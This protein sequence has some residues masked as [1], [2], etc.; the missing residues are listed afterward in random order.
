MDKMKKQKLQ[1][2]LYTV[3]TSTKSSFYRDHYN[4]QFTL[5]D[6]ENFLEKGDIKKIPMLTWKEIQSCHFKERSYIDGQILVKI[7]HRYST[8]FLFARSLGD[9][10]AEDYG[11]IGERPLMLF[12]Y[13]HEGIEKGLWIYE[14][15]ILPLVR[16]E[17]LDITGMLVQ[18]YRVDSILAESNMLF[19]FVPYLKRH[20]TLPAILH[21]TVI[22]HTF[23]A[24]FLRNTFSNAKLY[25]R[26]GL[27]ETGVFGIPCIHE[28]GRKD[29]LFHPEKNSIVEIQDSELIVTRLTEFPTP[30]IRY[31]TGITARI[32]ENVCPC[33]SKLSF[34]LRV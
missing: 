7:I 32:L 24:E 11:V 2:L 9:I 18:K 23:D 30:I 8:P 16:E 14:R 17:N 20:Y 12:E 19:T 3:L 1:K 31:K 33:E 25:L 29:I 28:R 15:N 4:N 26:L 22:D 5:R 34:S 10:G 21:L 13:C 6:A 27:S